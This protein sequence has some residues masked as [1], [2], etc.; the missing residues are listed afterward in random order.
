[1]GKFV[2]KEGVRRGMLVFR[3]CVGRDELGRARWEAD[4]DCGGK[5][6]GVPSSAGKKLRLLKAQAQR[7]KRQEVWFPRR[8]SVLS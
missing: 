2:S 3:R 5:W 6:V 4:C 7:L 8:R 1:M